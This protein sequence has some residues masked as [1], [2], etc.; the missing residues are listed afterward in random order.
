MGLRLDGDGWGWMVVEWWWVVDGEWLGW[1]GGGWGLG[2]VPEI[3][4]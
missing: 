1:D 3:G 2:G 4:S